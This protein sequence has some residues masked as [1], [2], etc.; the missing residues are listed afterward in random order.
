MPK[1]GCSL[2]AGCEPLVPVPDTKSSEP[3]Y[4]VISKLQPFRSS[5]ALFRMMPLSLPRYTFLSEF[6]GAGRAGRREEKQ[7]P[8][9]FQGGKKQKKKTPKSAEGLREGGEGRQ[10]ASPKKRRRKKGGNPPARSASPEQA[11]WS[12]RLFFSKIPPQ[13]TREAA[14]GGGQRCRGS[15]SLVSPCGASRSG[16]TTRGIRLVLDCGS[17]SASSG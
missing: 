11:N 5:S 17:G 14:C 3:S 16:E 12:C 15:G 10:T 9:S 6:I 8:I 7:P 4:L 2:S 13:A 1:C